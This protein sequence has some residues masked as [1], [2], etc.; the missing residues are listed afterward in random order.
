MSV[1][2]AVET[3]S[4]RAYEQLQYTGSAGPMSAI[5]DPAVLDR[6]RSECADWRGKYW[7]FTTDDRGV[8]RLRPI[9]VAARHATVAAA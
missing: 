7:S 9:N 6:W 8:L 2:L 1:A 3:I 4:R 5:E